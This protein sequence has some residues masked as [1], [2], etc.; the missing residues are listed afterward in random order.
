MECGGKGQARMCTE[1]VSGLSG[2]RMEGLMR[3]SSSSDA[4]G[5][6]GEGVED[7]GRWLNADAVAVA[8]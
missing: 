1:K 5:R 4:G 7:G 6:R 3:C 8:V 2:N